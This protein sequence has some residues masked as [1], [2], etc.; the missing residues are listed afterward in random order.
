MVVFLFVMTKASHLA[1]VDRVGC[2]TRVGMHLELVI[3]YGGSTRPPIARC[4]M[5]R[6]FSHL[7]LNALIVEV[8][9]TKV[10]CLLVGNFM[11]GWRQG[12]EV[13]ITLLVQIDICRVL[14][15]Q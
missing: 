5:V 13:A 15:L 12:C 1:Y 6:C 2:L 7:R 8:H 14:L 9:L 11:V 4:L 10:S 3:G